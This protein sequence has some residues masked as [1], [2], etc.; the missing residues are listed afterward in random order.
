MGQIQILPGCQFELSA[1]YEGNQK[2]RTRMMRTLSILLKPRNLSCGTWRYYRQRN[3][4]VVL[5]CIGSKENNI[6]SCAL[7]KLVW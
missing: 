4:I 2:N 7:T 3:L 5:H 1:S 6:S